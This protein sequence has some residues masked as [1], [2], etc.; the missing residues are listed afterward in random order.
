MYGRY[1]V[2]GLAVGQTLHDRP[3]G[4]GHICPP[5]TSPAA[6]RR[7]AESGPGDSH[8]VTDLGAEPTVIPG[9]GDIPVPISPTNDHAKP[10][11]LTKQRG[12][13][14][15]VVVM[16]THRDHRKPSVHRRKEWMI[17]ISAAVMWHLQHVGGNVSPDPE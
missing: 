17:R 1:H 12:S 7:T 4:G 5:V 8:R 2:L 14:L 13:R 15:A 3:A 16:R 6:L 9:H 10:I 11:Q